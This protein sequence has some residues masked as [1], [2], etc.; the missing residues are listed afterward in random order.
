MGLLVAIAQQAVRL[1]GSKATLAIVGAAAAADL[2]PFSDGG[3]GIPRRRR[4]RRAL[5]ASDKLDIA[6]IAGTLGKPAGK[7]FA[8]IVAS[9]PR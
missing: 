7:D 3:I 8:M 1:F 2:G 6:F 5:T 9:R 4:R